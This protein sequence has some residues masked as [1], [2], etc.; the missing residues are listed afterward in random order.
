MIT[1]KIMFTVI[2]LNQTKRLSL[3]NVQSEKNQGP[4]NIK[5]GQKSCYVIFKAGLIR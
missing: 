4:E 2:N 1:I 5:S 3:D